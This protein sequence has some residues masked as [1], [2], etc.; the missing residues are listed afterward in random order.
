MW[1]PITLSIYNFR[2]FKEQIFNFELGA[3]LVQGLNKTNPSQK[4]NGSGK[5]AFSEA[6]RYVLDLPTK[7]ERQTD[8]IRWGTKECEVLF[9]LKNTNKDTLTICRKTPLKGSSTLKIEL[10][11]K[12]QKDRFSTVPEGNKLIIELIGISKE[13]LVNHYIISSENYTSI[14]KSTTGTSDTK[15]KNLIGRFS[16]F[17]IID[18]VE[19][20][21][22][23]DIEIINSK[24]TTYNSEKDRLLGKL[25]FLEEELEKE[26]NIDLNLVKQGIIDE[27]NSAI[28]SHKEKIESEN[29][30]ILVKRTQIAN[31]KNENNEHL[32]SL[33]VVQKNL[34]SVKEV[35]Y[36]KE[37]K[38]VESSKSKFLKSKGTINESM[39]HLNENLRNFMN[40]KSEVELSVSGAIQ[41]PK[42]LHEF[43]KGEEIDVNEARKTIPEIEKEIKGIND[44]LN[45]YAERLSGID[46]SIYNL[47]SKL[48]NF[49]SKIDSLRREKSGYQLTISNIN[50]SIAI[51]NS[52]IVNL[53]ENIKLNQKNIEKYEDLIKEA[54]KGI[55]ESK[56]KSYSN[57]EKEI[58]SKIDEVNSEI[59]GKDK[60]IEEIKDELFKT[61]QWVY[62]FAKFRSHLANESLE[63][64]Q[65]YAN[66]YLQQMGSDLSLQLEGYKELK[67]GQLRE[68][69][70]SKVLRDGEV[71]GSGSLKNYS[72]GE[73]S[74]IDVC[75]SILSFQE[76][77]NNSS[78]TGGL[79]LLFVDEVYNGLD[80][81]GLELLV[82]ELD[83]LN[84]PSYIV[85]HTTHE[86]VPDNVITIEKINKISKFVS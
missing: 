81:L 14:L 66:M 78:P 19:D 31:I 75:T 22:K 24:L 36:G 63:I 55:E 74:R 49:Q 28:S 33:K 1:T 58:Q 52:K 40:F 10:N 9:T 57:N 85:S 44:S 46:N 56:N 15:V 65:G 27:F 4:S 3:Y 50:N 53:E 61:E 32:K 80:S 79:N 71:E 69:I 5:S 82:K 48:D 77:I 17:N 73:F 59:S 67:N 6:I 38:E 30:N 60:V 34:D 42:C 37:I 13:D 7:A 35:G 47:N 11:G 54:R 26:K 25:E 84:K 23:G 86:S 51:N 2:S 16:N 12:D 62:R 8:L 20:I 43:V 39:N 41:C 45:D 72:L 29:S 18:G 68:K 76:L 83:K 21:V 64:I 70:T